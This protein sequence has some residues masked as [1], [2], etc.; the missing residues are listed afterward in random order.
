M[1]TPV[2]HYGAIP[3]EQEGSLPD[4]SSDDNHETS[5]SLRP[6]WLWS[7]HTNTATTAVDGGRHP[8]PRHQ[9]FRDSLVFPLEAMHDLL[10]DDFRRSTGNLLRQSVTLSFG[11]RQ[12]SIRALGGTATIT[13]EFFNLVKNL[14]GAGML[15]LPSGV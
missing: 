5:T 2:V 11:G 8:H 7:S 12:C 10:G 15:A 13:N 3:S 14:V 6:S 1:A 4:G 9:S